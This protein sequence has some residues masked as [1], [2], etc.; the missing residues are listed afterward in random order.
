MYIRDADSV[1]LDI[2]ILKLGDKNAEPA[3]QKRFVKIINDFDSDISADFLNS[4][5][6]F[7]TGIR[8]YIFESY[9]VEISKA[10]LTMLNAIF[11]TISEPKSISMLGKLL[12]TA[13]PAN[14]DY[15]LVLLFRLLE[16]VSLAVKIVPFGYNELKVGIKGNKFLEFT[17]SI[18]KPPQ[19]SLTQEDFL[20]ALLIMNDEPD[21]DI[22]DIQECNTLTEYKR[23]INEAADMDIISLEKIPDYTSYPNMILVMGLRAALKAGKHIELQKETLE[24]FIVSIIKKQDIDTIVNA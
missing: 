10:T 2:V 17:E 16:R 9:N 8:K 3:E 18:Y 5:E 20:K 11:R 7:I 6:K 19:Q 23:V 21:G 13:K 12:F 22:S 14:L 4:Q 15:A 24:K 1:A